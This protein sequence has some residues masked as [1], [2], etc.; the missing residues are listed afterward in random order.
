MH[1]RQSQPKW[2]LLFTLR[3]VRK[4]Q[5]LELMY[6]VGKMRSFFGGGTFAKLR[7]ATISFVMSVRPSVRPPARMKQLRSHRTDFHET[8][9]FSIY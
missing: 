2:L 9:Y 3:I 8:R 7:R 5:K 6:P 4:A 1:S